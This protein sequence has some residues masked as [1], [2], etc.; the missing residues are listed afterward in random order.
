MAHSSADYRKML[1]LLSFVSLLDTSESKF[2]SPGIILI[3][4]F[5]PS[6]FGLGQT[7]SIGSESTVYSKLLV[8]ISRYSKVAGNQKWKATL[9]AQ[10]HGLRESMPLRRRPLKQATACD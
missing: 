10:S 9:S 3:A 4:C 7:R 6:I 1:N 5:I 2:R 8:N